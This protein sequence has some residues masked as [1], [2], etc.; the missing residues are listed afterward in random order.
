[1]PGLQSTLAREHEYL[2]GLFERL[3]AAFHANAGAELG[4]LWTEFDSRL[5]SHMTLEEEYILPEFAKVEVTEANELRREHVRI[6]ELLAELDIAVDL[7]L[8]R[9]STIADLVALLKAHAE[10]EDR[11]MYRWAASNLD[12][13]TRQTIRAEIRRA[14]H[15]IATQPRAGSKPTAG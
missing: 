5:R 6:R 9:E 3:L 12:T 15:N 13:G 7:H 4:P 10:R 11:L 8:A 14:F 2:N 1:M